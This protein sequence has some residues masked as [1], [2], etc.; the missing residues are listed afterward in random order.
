MGKVFSAVEC[1]RQCHGVQ[2]CEFWTYQ[3][4]TNSCYMKES[5][6]TPVH[7][8]G[9]ISGPRICPGPVDCSQSGIDLFGGGILDTQVA[10]AL[11]CQYQCTAVAD[12]AFWTFI[13]STSRCYMKGKNVD[14]QPHAEAISGPRECP[15]TSTLACEISTDF[16]GHDLRSFHGTVTDVQSCQ[17]LCRGFNNCFYWTFVESTASCYLKDETAEQGREY[18][19]LTFSITT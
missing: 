5:G 11:A 15:V 9:L 13:P 1:Q 18:N 6:A 17:E 4:S 7:G 14:P 19:P 12:C 2:N 8:E 3:P 16:L 10:N